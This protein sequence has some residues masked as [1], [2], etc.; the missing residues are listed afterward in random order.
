MLLGKIQGGKTRTFMGII[1]LAF[2]KGYDTCVVLTKGTKALTTQTFQRLDGEFRFLA[3]RD[4]IKVYDIMDIPKLTAYLRKQK[5]IIVVKKETNNL[6]RLVKF[7]N[8]YPD[9][10]E[11]RTLLI[12]DE[13]DIASVGFRKDQTQ[14]DGVSINVIAKKI[15]GIRTGFA[16][17]YSFLQVTATP[18]SLYLQPRSKVELDNSLFQPMRPVFTSLVPIHNKYVGGKEYFESSQDPN[19]VYSYLYVQVPDKEFEILGD[20]DRRY[21]SSVFTT[22]NL[23][24]FRQAIINYLVGGSIRIIQSQREAR[25]YKSSFVIHT[26]STKARHQWQVELT[27]ALI[28][29]LTDKAAKGDSRLKSL[30]RVA[31]D[32]FVTSIRSIGE[33]PPPFDHVVSKV[34]EVLQDGMVGMAK[35]NSENAISTLLDRKGQLRLDNPFNIF[36]GGQI[37]DRGLTIENFIGFFYGRNPNTFQQ[38]TV[39]QHSR[40]YGS[41]EPRDVA[42]TRLYTSNRIYLALK[43]IHVFDSALREAFEKGVQTGGDDGVVFIE[44]DDQ[45]KIRPCAPNK[46]LITSTET[47]RPSTRFLPIGFQTRSKSAIRPT[48]EKIDKIV[49]EESGGNPYAPFLISTEKAIEIAN[50]INQTFLYGDKW[51]NSDYEWDKNTFIAIIRRLVDNVANSALKGKLYCFAETGRNVSRLKNDGT[52]FTDAPDDGKT[53]IPKAKGVAAETPCLILLKQTGSESLGWEDVPFWWPVLLT[54]ANARTAVF[55]TKTLDT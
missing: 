19:T 40:M 51:Q 54:P 25:N 48:I 26:T 44:S 1:A 17:N 23:Q 30:E 13:A 12:D 34:E 52:A 29:I 4:L 2:D 7:F 49:E 53:D 22:P 8:N 32:N 39:L 35:V 20:R 14:D 9:L 45:G 42:V 18:Y 46:I 3:D 16:N 55:A 41:R 31:Y 38:D 47:I 24:V 5:L 36:I 33:T 43:K 21:L 27:D 37:L 15:S 11:K 50:L 28:Q 10:I 6:D